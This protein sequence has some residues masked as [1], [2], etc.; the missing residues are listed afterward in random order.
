MRASDLE[1]IFSYH[2][3]N[4]EQLATYGEIRKRALEFA[5]FLY[6]TCPDSAERTLAIRDLQKAMMFA[7][8]SVAIHT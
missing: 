3:A 2:P 1:D 5:L 7:N 4:D 6:N 8:A